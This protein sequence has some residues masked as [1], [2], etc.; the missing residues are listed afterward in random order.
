M[1]LGSAKREIFFALEYYPTT[2]PVSLVISLH[3]LLPV[4]LLPLVSFTDGLHWCAPTITSR[5]ILLPLSELLYRL[6]FIFDLTII[7]LRPDL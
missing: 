1:F 6:S 7:D 5:L 2:H 3:H 4:T